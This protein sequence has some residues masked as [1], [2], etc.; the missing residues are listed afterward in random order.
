[1]NAPEH[2]P[3]TTLVE[4]QSA[5][6]SLYAK[7][8]KIHAH[9]VGGKH[10][11]LRHVIIF[12]I[13]GGLVLGPWLKWEGRQALLLDLPARQ[14]HIFG[15]DFWPQDLWMLGW[16][17]MIAAFALFT[18]TNIVGRLWCGYLCPQTLWTTVFMAIDRWVEGS[19]RKR[20][21][22][23]EQSWD[24]TK[25]A[26]RACTYLLY[27]TVAIVTSV[28]FV[29]YFTPIAELVHNLA[30]FNLAVLGGWTQFW[31]A[32]FVA[33]TLFAAGWAREQICIY[34]CPYARFQGSMIDDDTLI[35]SYD[36]KRGDP[37][38]SKKQDAKL[39]DCVDCQLCVQV[40]PTGI[41]IRE[42]LQYQCIGCAHCI[43]ACDQVMQKIGR[44]DGLIRYTSLNA[45]EGKALRWMRPRSIGYATVCAMFCMAFLFAVTSRLTLDLDVLR[46]R[47]SLY[48]VDQNGH[49]RNDY[50]LKVMN[51]TSSPTSYTVAVTTP[52]WIKMDSVPRLEL[53][54][55][56]LSNVPLV[57]VAAN[58]PD[59]ISDV[60]VQLCSADRDQ[61]TSET[62]RFIAPLIDNRES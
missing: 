4:P 8:N 27:L 44:P 39:G 16:L 14:F 5:P 54:A 17:L 42:G 41:D 24:L 22:L 43:D 57:L 11:N 46:D 15:L 13:L 48:Q 49:V 47:S 2:I 9:H 21:R 18:I 10:Q 52:D 45:L 12:A 3:V 23:Q 7:R 53:A 1:M 62:T 26:R 33:S 19:S 35:V 58:P 50:Q 36:A 29:G 51:K 6:V 20:K 40:C 32:F 30:N 55:G 61:C 25:L 59:G 37:R 38:G 60:T 31:L 34:M 56:E 28:T